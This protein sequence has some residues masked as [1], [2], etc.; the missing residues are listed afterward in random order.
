[1][2]EGTITADLEVAAQP[3]L[4][5][6]IGHQYRVG[7]GRG[8]LTDHSVASEHRA[9][10]ADPELIARGK[11]SHGQQS[12]VAPDG[13]R[14]GY[15]C[16]VVAARSRR[17]AQPPARRADPAPLAHG[18]PVA[19]ATGPHVHAAC[20]AP[21]R[22]RADYGCGVGVCPDAAAYESA[23]AIRQQCAA[24]DEQLVAR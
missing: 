15:G 23:D 21:P 9:A 10:V 8:A 16:H 1:M 22:I 6:R 5:T 7:A 17:H 24:A 20:D 18:Q 2:V 12:R 4:R 14:A 13:P 11:V 3:P 19:C